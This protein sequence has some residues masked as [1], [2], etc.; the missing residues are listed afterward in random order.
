MFTNNAVARIC[1]ALCLVGAG[2]HVPQAMA[3]PEIEDNDIFAERQ[4]LD[5]GT[6]TVEGRLGLYSVDDY[7][8]SVTG[9]LAPGSFDSY[10]LTAADL[11]GFVAGTPFVTWT[12]NSASGVDTYIRTVD[13]NGNVLDTDDDGGV[14]LSS[15]IEGTANA[16][17]S[18]RVD[19]T[20]YGDPGFNGGHGQNGQYDLRVR[21]N[22]PEVDDIDFFT[23][24][25]LVIG[26]SYSAEITSVTGNLDT[27][28]GVFD[29]AGNL[30]SFNDDGGTGLLSLLSGVVTDGTLTF[31]VT[32]YGDQGSFTGTHRKGDYVLALT[33][34]YGAAPATVP[35]P[36]TLA[37]SLL[38]LG[39]AAGAR[40]RA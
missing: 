22:L 2:L 19:V 6:T 16:D 24:S 9:T 1:G 30:V 28:L 26:S 13:E 25:N 36:A 34:T 21:Q 4:L 27:V 29:S 8:F 18:V 20:G 33:A 15:R 39:I 3:T 40:R 12:D 10:L 14:G 32:G 31:A 23:F 5:Y 37:L 35:A 17:G 38:G 11:P 7:D